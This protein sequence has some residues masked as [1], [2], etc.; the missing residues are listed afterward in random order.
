M[1][2]D[3]P[4]RPF[5]GVGAIV[6]R[7][8]AVLLVKRG[9]A[10]RAGEWSIPGGAQHL[11]ETV[12]DAVRREVKEETGLDIVIGGIVDVVDF[13]DKDDSGLVRHHYSLIDLWADA[14]SGQAVPGDDV[15]DVTW[16]TLETLSRYGLW[17]ETERVIELAHS[18]RGPIAP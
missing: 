8:N 9:K 6:W 3:Y 12:S 14:E 11:G 16:A 2:R 1:K 10:P 7:D 13:I 4:D 15:I 17:T 5:V 18:R